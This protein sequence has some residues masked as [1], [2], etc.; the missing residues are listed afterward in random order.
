[1]PA[2]TPW[3]EPLHGVRRRAQVILQRVE[4]A[5]AFASVLL[6]Q[7]ESELRDRRD[8]ALLH[9][10]VMGVLR[11]QARLDHALDRCADRP[12]AAMDPLVR[13]VLRIGAYSLLFLDRVPDFAAVNSAVEQVKRGPRRSA[14]SFVN[15]VLRRLASRRAAVLPPEP[16]D[17]DVEALALHRSHPLWWTRRVVERLGWARADAL[18]AANNEPAP[19]VLRP[20][21]RKIDA[22]GLAARLRE[23]GVET[24]RCRFAEGALRVVSGNPAAAGVFAEGLAWVQDEAAQLVPVLLGDA[25]PRSLDLCAAPGG[26]TFHMADRL[27]DGSPVVALDRHRGRLKRLVKMARLLG[28][29][30]ILP[31]VADAA[32][33]GAAL[34][35]TFDAVLLDAPCSGTG[36]LRRHPEIRWRLTAGDIERLARRQGVLLRRA[37]ERVAPGGTLVYSVCSIEP[38]EGPETIT[39]FLAGHPGFALVDP[40]LRLPRGCETLV[41]APGFLHTSPDNGGLDGFFAAVLRRSDVAEAGQGSTTA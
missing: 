4:T 17:G 40:A 18:L 14:A 27:P 29:A 3:A 33:P 11:E 9:R 8:A 15:G 2:P 39:D 13:V 20:W 26:K 32:A 23:S 19:T 28:A 35:G 5:G 21:S 41:Q 1:M 31:L 25:G 16:A 10:I 6:E 36:T 37:A 38:E 22:D 34:G 24:E 12:T 7:H 30:D